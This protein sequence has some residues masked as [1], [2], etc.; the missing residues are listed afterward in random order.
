MERDSAVDAHAGEEQAFGYLLLSEE[1][2]SL[3]KHST[4]CARSLCLWGLQNTETFLKIQFMF[5]F[6]PNWKW[7]SNFFQ[8]HR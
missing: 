8:L 3:L 7:P 5:D 6:V 2:Q 1:K 4:D